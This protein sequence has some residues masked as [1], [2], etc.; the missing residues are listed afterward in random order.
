MKQST[1]GKINKSEEVRKALAENPK[2]KSKEIVALLAAKGLKVQPH[3]VYYIKSTDRKKKR[4]H[5]R[6]QAVEVSQKM[7]ATN[8]VALILKVKGLAIEAG[9][10]RSLKQ[11]VDA[12]AE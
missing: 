6:Q 7:G 8:P 3:L 5:R 2:A 9:G 10:L 12:L 4:K 1:D 11:L